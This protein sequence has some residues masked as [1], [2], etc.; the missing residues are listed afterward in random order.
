MH[1]AA[2]ASESSAP[3][4]AL[5]SALDAEQAQRERA[6][7]HH[8]LNTVQIP[9]LR[10]IGFVLLSLAALIFDLWQAGEIGRGFA[11][12]LA[13]NTGYALAGAV[14]LRSAYGR[15]RFD[16]NFVLLHLDVAV[17]L[18]TFHYV[19]ATHAVFAFFALGRVADQV[20]YGFRRAF[21][22]NHVTVGIYVA[23]ALGLAWRDP[24]PSRLTLQLSIALVMYMVGIYISLTGLAT[25]RLREGTRAAVRRARE[26]LADLEHKTAQLQAQTLDLDRARREAEQANLAKSQ[27]LATMSHEIRTPMSGILGTTELL[28]GT[29]LTPSQRTL[30]Q[31]SQTSGAALLAIVND[32]LELSRVEAGMVRLESAPLDPQA[33]IEDIVKLMRATARSKGLELQCRVD[34]ALARP[35]LGDAG[36]LRQVLLNLVGN[37]IKFTP[38]GGVFVEADLI[39]ELPGSVRLRCSVRDTGI[40][41]APDKHRAIFERFVQADASTTR[42]YG[43]SG[44]GLSIAREI[45]HLMGGALDVHSEPGKGSTF[46]FSIEL[47]TSD[48]ALPPRAAP[49]S[50]PLHLHA[51]VLLA[52]DNAINRVVIESMLTKLGCRVD[53]APDGAAALNA[54]LTRRYDLIFMDCHMPVMDGYVATRRIRAY[55]AERGTRRT[56]I[57]A[58]TAGVFLEDRASCTAA[59]MDDFLGKPVSQAELA[60]VIERWVAGAAAPAPRAAKAGATSAA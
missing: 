24:D 2:A 27:F 57:V 59:G 50:T 51:S 45:V 16:V 14:L 40:G 17:S 12:V 38:R 46:W 52:E 49:H 19:D 43:G 22:F 26:L 37:A 21:Y 48:A 41:I 58:L 1:D 13:V 42:T 31:A 56:P 18:L 60:Q 5:D 53:L 4:G 6:A 20:G 44:L 28:L 25:G 34:P 11:L 35:L 30:V 47:P 39:A 29:E 15:T 55:E 36:R 8:R 32:V 10:G 23:Y 33:L 9:L 7:R 54:T 3:R